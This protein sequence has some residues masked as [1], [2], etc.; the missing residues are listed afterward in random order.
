LVV[1]HNF[2]RF[3]GDPAGAF[4]ARLAAGAAR[5]GSA[6]RVVAPHAP[7]LAETTEQAGVRI[8]R[9]RYAPDGL[10]TVAYTG[11]MHRKAL[12]SLRMAV[13][14]PWFLIGIRRAV[15]RAVREHSPDVIHAHWWLPSAW[16]A[17]NSRVPMVI[18][19]H[20][21]DVRLL[22]HAPLRWLGRSVLRRAA[23]VTTVSSFLERDVKRAAPE[24]AE[25]VV[26]EPM[27][28]DADRWIRAR[29]LPRPEPPVV[30]YAGNLLPSK[31]V[32]T[33]LEA[34]ALLARR[35]IAV[36][37]RILGEGPARDDLERRAQA[38]AL[39][40]V[41]WSDFVNQDAMVD[42]YGRATTVVLPTRNDAEGLGLV[43]VEALFAGCAV[44]GTRS[45]GIPDVVEDQVTGR[46]VPPDDPAAMAAAIAD[47][48][49]PANRGR[50]SGEAERR[51]LERFGTERV[52]DRYLEVYERA[53]RRSS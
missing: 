35:G 33:L 13:A 4:V 29:S 21:S 44:V 24:V 23:I 41:E 18:T 10:E 20:G 34:V 15:Q 50:W 42:E 49:D 8:D 28:I 36:R 45:G 30:L 9:F 11:Q 12:R 19:C 46:L 7:G 51:L 6:V 31:G 16:A 48:L 43:L 27:P 38:L 53:R 39:A 47:T 2:P 14:L 5:R 1:T 22:D 17:A 25:R 32:D 40:G 26:V 52:V 3:D 37:T